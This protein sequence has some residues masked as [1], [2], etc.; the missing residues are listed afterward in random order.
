MPKLL[1]EHYDRVQEDANIV[2]PEYLEKTYWWAYVRPWAVEFWERELFIDIILWFHYKKLRNEALSAFGKD[3]SGS[4][5]QMSC[6]YGA[7]TPMFWEK[8]S[9]DSGKLTVI[10]VVKHQLA[11]LNRKLPENHSVDLINMNASD[12]KFSDEE[13]DR[14]MLFFLP[15]ELPKEARDKT[16]EEALRVAKPGAE[17]VIVEFSKPKWWHPL[18]Y[19]YLPFL[20][21]LEPFAPDIWKTDEIKDWVPEK[22]SDKLIKRKKIFGDYYQILTFKV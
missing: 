20:R 19:I 21:F 2:V 12:L 14:V 16:L 15:H 17:I 4:M 6:A 18:R 7:L 11:N 8:I 3:L 5:L 1:P 10:D 13:F 22:L 9:K